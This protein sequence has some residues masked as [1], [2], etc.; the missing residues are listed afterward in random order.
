MRLKSRDNHKGE[1]QQF[2]PTE[3]RRPQK[4]MTQGRGHLR[5]P[6]K[7]FVCVWSVRASQGPGNTANSDLILSPPTPP[8]RGGARQGGAP[9]VSPKGTVLKERVKNKLDS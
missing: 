2:G 9:A 1:S 6:A 7:S 5:S 4:V 3:D 8:P